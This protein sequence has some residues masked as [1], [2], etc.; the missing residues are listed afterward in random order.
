MS[1]RDT[2]PLGSVGPRRPRRSEQSHRNWQ[3]IFAGWLLA[4]GV[5]AFFGLLLDPLFLFSGSPTQED[6]DSF[7]ILVALT[8]SMAVVSVASYQVFVATRVEVTATHVVL[9]NP[10]RV[11]TLP[12]AGLKVE[13]YL[14]YPR[15]RYAGRTHTGWGAENAAPDLVYDE[16][17]EADRPDGVAAT[18]ETR[19]RRPGPFVLALVTFWLTYIVLGVAHWWISF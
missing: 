13:P 12:R 1:P 15:L 7:L 10:L 11:T 16:Q 6:E 19:W 14:G 3:N 17:D 2:T 4:L 8:A 18:A 5:P 9:W